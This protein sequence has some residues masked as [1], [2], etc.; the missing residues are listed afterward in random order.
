MADDLE[1]AKKRLADEYGQ[2][3]RR[4]AGSAHLQH[5]TAPRVVISDERAE[6]LE[7]GGGVTKALPL[8]GDNPFYVANA[9]GRLELQKFWREMKKQEVGNVKKLKEAITAEIE[10]N[11]F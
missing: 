5:R 1:H 3:R 9:D 11:C 8:L 10:K 2:T 4:F 7:T 6:R